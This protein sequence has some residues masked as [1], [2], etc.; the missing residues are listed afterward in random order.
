MSKNIKKGINKKIVAIGFMTP[1]VIGLVLFLALVSQNYFSTPSLAITEPADG[2]TVQ[3]NE[4]VTIK[5]T[6]SPKQAR[7]FINDIALHRTDGNIMFPTTLEDEVNTF[8][9]RAENGGKVEQQTITINRVFTD[10]E[11]AQIAKKKAEKEAL[12]KAA[13]EKKIAEQKA[14]EQSRAGKLCTK[15][16]TWSKQECESVAGRKYWI[17]MTYEMLV[18]SY[19]SRPNHANPSNYGSGTSW[20]WCWTYYTPSCF[21]D[22]N[23]DGI[24]DAYN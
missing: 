18:E 24:V 6:F 21:Y 19:G 1:L 4:L 11:K 12:E 13:I 14:W 20:Q 9:V 7:V 16:P 8:V 5:G 15:Y 22:E 17:G 3:G 10:E 2:Y 23:D